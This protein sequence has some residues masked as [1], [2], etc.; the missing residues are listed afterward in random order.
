MAKTFYKYQERD[1][2]NRVNYADIGIRMADMIT[3]Q[4]AT[5]KAKKEAYDDQIT[6]FGQYLAENP[7]GDDVNMTA[8]TADYASQMQAM[9]LADQRAFKS[10]NK[11]ERDHIVFMQNIQNGTKTMFDLSKEYQDEYKIKMERMNS[12]DPANKS[13][14]LEQFLMNDA[15]G[16]FNYKDTKPIIDPETGLILVSRKNKD[17]KFETVP[18]QNLR[19][20]IK[21]QV[22]Y[23]DADAATTA[24][25]NGIGQEITSALVA[26]GRTKGGSITEVEDKEIKAGFQ[27][28]L[29]AQLKSYLA[30]ETNI[31]SILTNSLKDEKYTFT[32]NRDEAEADPTK[33]LL[34]IEPGGDGTPVPDFSTTHGKAQEQKALD[35]LYKQT[36]QKID[37][38]VGKDA[39][40]A[41]GINADVGALAWG[42]SQKEKTDKANLYAEN[43]I[44]A[45][46]STDAGVAEAAFTFLGTINK[47]VTDLSQDSNGDLTFTIGNKKQ[48]VPI[49]NKS[50]TQIATSL[51]NYIGIPGDV[52]NL[53]LKKVQNLGG[54][55][56]SNKNREMKSF[57][58]VEE[59]IPKKNQSTNTSVYNTK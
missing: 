42:A 30:T 45:F 9:M 51:Q 22:N 14:D 36:I 7:K 24:V 56:I 27:A 38:K 10:G 15:G 1:L 54:S 31:S 48:T 28:A 47:N 46:G 13:Q 33:I 25:E 4:I 6:A 3:D 8:W 40:S 57:E 21:T 2:D 49:K 29:T 53:V 35:F 5:R 17:G 39:I 32:Y 34:T 12:N 11:S 58:Y 50:V 55:K 43:L 26:A 41:T 23:F 52:Q 44:K 19:T 16:Y 37:R 18:A 20:R 59:S